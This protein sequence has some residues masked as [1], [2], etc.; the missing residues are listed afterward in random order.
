MN[1]VS[2]ITPTMLNEF[3]VG[4]SHSLSEAESV[5]G[6]V[7]RAA[8]GME[9]LRILFPL[10]PDQSIPDYEL[11]WPDNTN[12]AGSYLGGTPWKQANTTINVNDNVTWVLHKP[13]A[14]GRNLLPAQPEGPASVG[15]H[16][17]A[18]RRFEPGRRPW[19]CPGGVRTARC[20]D[21]FASALS[22]E[23]D[24]FDQSTARPLGKFRYNQL[25]FYI[26]D[27]WK[28]IPRLTLDYGMRF[29][30]IPPQYDA[31]TKLLCSIPSSYNPANAVTID[32]NSGTSFREDG[33]DP[34]NGMRFANQGTRSR[35]EDGIAAGIMA[36]PRLGFAYDLFGN[37]QDRFCAAVLA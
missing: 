26:Q 12:F 19:T 7:S 31:T 1:L 29:A 27:T 18:V 36:E 37:T 35:K 3:S 20:G 33:G 10:A 14:Q 34:L 2:T 15:K 21:P 6:N 22:G 5:N 4:P 13:H 16:Q 24:G 8:N 11:Q 28:F 25:E 23:F 32:P 30:W 17:R 9:N